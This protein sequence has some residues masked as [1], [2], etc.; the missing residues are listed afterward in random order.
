[1]CK[2]EIAL[3]RQQISLELVAMRQGL[4]GIALG[5]ARHAFIHTRMERVAACQD[6]LADEVGEAV[7]CEMVC[8][9]YAQAMEPEVVPD[10]VS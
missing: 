7:A 9:L 4:Q 6:S 1:M 8:I 10:V 2:S 3:L 5:T